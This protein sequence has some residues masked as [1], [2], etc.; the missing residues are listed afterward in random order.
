MEKKQVEIESL[1]VNNNKEILM[2]LEICASAGA[3]LLRNGAESYRVEDT[4]ERIIKSRKNIKDADVYS[5]F[6]VIMVS[7]N[8][9]GEVYTNLRRVKDRTTNLIFVDRVNSF[10][11]KF[12]AGEYSIEEALIELDKMK[13]TPGLSNKLVTAGAASAAAAFC[14]LIGGSLLESSLAFLVGLLS[15]IIHIILSKKSF[16]YFID[17]FFNGVIVSILTIIF[18]SILKIENMDKI[19]IGA[20]MA[21]LPGVILTNAIRDLMSGD[22]TTGLTG[23]TQ[24]ILI[25]TSLAIG[26]ALPISIFR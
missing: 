20:I 16:G 5:T 9:D 6:N 22:T 13:K 25:A 8:V 7:F 21:Y 26:V 17:N 4:V 15:W 1:K 24:A 19:I 3:I 18:V 23:I 10:S 14:Y 12:C 11:R 2:L